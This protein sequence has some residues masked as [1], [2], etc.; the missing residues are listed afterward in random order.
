MQKLIKEKNLRKEIS[1]RKKNFF[2]PATLASASS[3]RHA[4]GCDRTR[5]AGTRPWWWKVSAC[6]GAKSKLSPRQ[7]PW[8]RL[9]SSRRWR[10][11]STPASRGTDEG[12]R[13]AAPSGFVIRRI[14]DGGKFREA[15]RRWW[16]RLELTSPRGR[17]TNYLLWWFSPARRSPGPSASARSSGS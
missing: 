4:R 12:K 14:W 15:R 7:S 9:G 6:R 16:W 3:Q 17:A 1:R 11:R 8:W 10:R 13:C 2:P 5:P